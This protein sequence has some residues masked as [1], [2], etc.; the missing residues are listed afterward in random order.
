MN[1]AV[2]K[3]P[4]LM[5]VEEFYDWPGDGTGAIYE[6]VDGVPRAQDFPSDA[7]GAIQ[8]RLANIVTR[9]L[10]TSSAGCRMVIN[11][12]IKPR[13]QADW[14]HRIPELGVTC[15]P[16]RADV[17]EFPDA[18]LLIEVLSPSNV[19]DT[20]GNIALYATVPTVREILVVDSRK[21]EAKILRRSADGIWPPN[22]EVITLD[23]TIRLATIDLEFPLLG[24]YRDTYLAGGGA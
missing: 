12:G 19:A 10:D 21:V 15:T 20:W 23:G 11:P 4:P 5:T 6:L 1:S 17:R 9:H 16:N 2:R 13:L 14:N 18:F 8:N 3:L 24:V 22:P 7:H